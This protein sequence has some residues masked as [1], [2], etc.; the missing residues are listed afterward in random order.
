V[1]AAGV[2][3]LTAGVLLLLLDL[4][5]VDRIGLLAFLL[6]LLVAAVVGGYLTR[7]IAPRLPPVGR[8]PRA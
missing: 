1:L 4:V 6:V 5:G 7:V 3:V 2:S 8:R